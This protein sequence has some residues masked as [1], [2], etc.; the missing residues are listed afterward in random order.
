VT[1]PGGGGSH[2]EPMVEIIRELRMI[3]EKL[4]KR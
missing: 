2:M 4:D 3:S 1:S